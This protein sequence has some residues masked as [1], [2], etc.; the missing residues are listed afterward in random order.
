MNKYKIFLDQYG[1]P[2]WTDFQQ[3][4]RRAQ[5]MEKKS[6]GLPYKEI[7][8]PL[9]ENVHIYNAT[10][11]KNAG[12]SNM[13]EDVWKGNK[14]TK[15]YPG[16]ELPGILPMKPKVFDCTTWHYIC[17][18]HRTTGSGASFE[19]DHGYRNTIIPELIKYDNI[20]DMIEVIRT[21]SKPM[22]T[23]KGNQIPPFNKPTTPYS[24]GGIEY[25]CEIAPIL[26][27]AYCK[28][29]NEQ[30]KPIGI[31]KAVDW[32]LDYQ[33]SLGWKR[34]KFVLTAFAMDTAEYY[35][36][37]VDPKSHCYYGKN[38]LESLDLMF[39][40]YLTYKDKLKRKEKYDLLMEYI[41]EVCRKSNGDS[42]DPYS[43]E[44]VFCDY[45][46]YIEN[47]VPKWYLDNYE[48]SKLENRSMI[49][50][51]PNFLRDKVN[52]LFQGG[53]FDA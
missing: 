22:F 18:V 16:Q 19:P 35:P 41:C 32:M 20:G 53:L 21:H 11:R 23:S 47:Y 45:I 38:A 48:W 34:F 31:Q 46:R 33:S 29:L 5:E 40:M 51:E 9:M 39:P 13:L 10:E 6:L 7:Q 3:Y 27:S 42:S 24:K 44:D 50:H 14:N 12:F 28:M 43:M 36:N 8:D 25:L 17:L 49:N 2:Y 30:D 1:S 37:L 26:S 52:Q 15:T 4:Y